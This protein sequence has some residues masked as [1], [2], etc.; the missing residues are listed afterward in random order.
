MYLDPIKSSTSAPS[1]SAASE[2]FQQ[3]SATSNTSNNS[4]DQSNKIK[5]TSIEMTENVPSPFIPDHF[6]IYREI[7]QYLDEVDYN[8]DRTINNVKQQK[9]PDDFQTEMCIDFT[10]ENDTVG[11]VPK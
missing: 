1:L 4:N 10:I 2:G 5:Y 3:K 6:I 9:M 8:C 11:D 7:Y